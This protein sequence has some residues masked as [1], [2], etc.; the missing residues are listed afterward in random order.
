[1]TA[2]APRL[3]LLIGL[4]GSGKSTLAQ[5]LVNHCPTRHLISTDAIRA[6]LFGDEAIQG[7]WSLIWDELGQQF[8]RAIVQI[9]HGEASEAIYD[10]TNAVRRQRRQVMMLARAC[11]FSELVGLWL[12]VPLNVCLE[13]NQK[14]DRQV[15]E[16]VILRMHRCLQGAPPDLQEGFKGLHHYVHLEASNAQN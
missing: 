13:R 14:R 6:A 16:A 7:T 3:L 8:Q 4:P 10:A 9:K 15:P 12:D 11:G 1:M 5:H 2:I